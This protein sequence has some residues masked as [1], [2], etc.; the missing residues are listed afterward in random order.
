MSEKLTVKVE[1]D[2]CSHC[3][4]FEFIG[5]GSGHTYCN[6][7]EAPLSIKIDQHYIPIECPRAINYAP[8]KV[9]PIVVLINGYP[10]SGKD[11][12]CDFAQLNYKTTNYSTVDT[13]KDIAAIMG[14]YGDKTPHN[15]NMLSALKDFY[16]KWFDGT[17]GEMVNLINKKYIEK[18][19]QFIFLHT[20]E[21]VEIKRVLEWCTE[22]NV[23]CYSVF[24]K[25]EVETVHGNHADANVSMFNYDIY[26][27]NDGTLD[28][29][30]KK[31]LDIFKKMVDN[32]V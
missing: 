19:D 5:N 13:V 27:D 6:H 30:K 25:R 2:R 26:I 4:N 20:R 10:E 21:P 8:N 12:F 24:I 14:W 16:V 17:F 32:K 31:S 1:I 29:F 22:S 28:E 9:I 7:H 23:K 3:P 11:T 15:R 18:E